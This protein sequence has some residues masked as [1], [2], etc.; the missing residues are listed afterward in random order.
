PRY[1]IRTD[2]L[3][4][5]LPPKPAAMPRKRLA[6][7]VVPALAFG[8]MAAALVPRGY[9]AGWLL[10]A[11][12]A[13]VK[14]ADH[15]VAERLTPAVAEPECAAPAGGGRAGGRGGARGR[16]RRS[17]Q[18]FRPSRDRARHHHQA[19][20]RG[21]AGECQLD[22]GECRAQ[23]PQLRLGTLLRPADRHGRAGRHRR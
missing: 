14:L 7:A 8:A 12:D 5:P 10:L 1:E 19:G 15:A 17:R 18:K 9:D 4:S 6:W 23:R 2:T 16:R 13:P 3:M 22:L 20:A 21:A 11:Q